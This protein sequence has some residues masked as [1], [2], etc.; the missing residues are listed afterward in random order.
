[1]FCAAIKEALGL[2][3]L[4]GRPSLL[5]SRALGRV[6]AHEI[7]H[8]LAPAFGHSAAG[9]MRARWRQETLRDD[10][11]CADAATSRAVR[12]Q[13]SAAVFEAGTEAPADLTRAGR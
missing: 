4:R 13:Q 7:T 3:D 12:A 11:L 2:D 6:A 5:L 8:V 1:M 9:L 10:L